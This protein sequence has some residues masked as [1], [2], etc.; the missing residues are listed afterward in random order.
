MQL[1]HNISLR[2]YNTFHM[3]VMA[4]QFIKFNSVASLQHLLSLEEIVRH[5]IL[6]L[7]G[8]SNILLTTDFKGTVLKNEIKGMEIVFEDDHEIRIRAGAGEIWHEFVM[9]CVSNGWGGV[10]NLALIPGTVGASPMQNIG[11]YGVELQQVFYEAEAVSMEDGNIYRFNREACKF[12]YRES[13]FKHELKGKMI[14]THV[15]FT[16]QKTP[17]IKTDYGAIRDE[18]K[19][20]G[21]ENP[22]VCD[23]ASAV[24]SIRKSKLPD[25][26]VLGNAGSFFKNP[27]IE[28]RDFE[29]LR[30]QYP[31]MVGY[32]LP[33]FK[34]KIAAGWLIEKA[35]WKGVRYGD[36]G[37]HEKQALVLINYGNAT[38]YDLFQ[39]SEQIISSVHEKFGIWL[40]R[41]VNIY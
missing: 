26:L 1:E 3:D 9:Y 36:A 13:V 40:H 35:G 33:D 24:I 22:G 30:V 14:I 20:C 19:K 2:P 31:E 6:I 12:G 11:A 38:G 27:E 8:G 21:V 23:V 17:Q 32:H 37:C 7:G 28:L 25:P 10:E 29:S 39:L 34:V 15:T 18:L 4:D 5:P 16:L 41:E